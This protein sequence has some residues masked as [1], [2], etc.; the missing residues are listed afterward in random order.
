[1]NAS[2][3]YASFRA[4]TSQTHALISAVALPIFKGYFVYVYYQ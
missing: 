3:P 1:M 4:V 2:N